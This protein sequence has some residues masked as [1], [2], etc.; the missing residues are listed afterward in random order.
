MCA[1]AR[2]AQSKSSLYISGSCACIPLETDHARIMQNNKLK[3]KVNK[4]ERI[5]IELESNVK[6]F[7]ADLVSSVLQTFD[8]ARTLVRILVR[9]YVFLFK[10]G[11]KSMKQD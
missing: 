11:G 4:L 10:T 8:C 2:H 1:H 7:Q 5:N 9:L 6:K 3:E